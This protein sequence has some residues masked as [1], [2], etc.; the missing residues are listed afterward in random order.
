MTDEA[1]DEFFRADFARLIAFLVKLGYRPEDAEDAAGEAMAGL[2]AAWDRV[3]HPAAWVR[4]VAKRQALRFARRDVQRAVREVLARRADGPVDD[5]GPEVEDVL[6]L[7]EVL[8]DLR[9]RER[10]VVVMSM[11]GFTSAEIA[12]HLAVTPATVR[13]HLRRA[14]ERLRAHPGLAGLVTGVGRGD[15]RWK[16]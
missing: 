15:S 1:F 6:W 11:E 16:A 5:Q 3:E 10:D 4:L 2:C 13:S 8:A 12:V 9:P 14:R 7:A